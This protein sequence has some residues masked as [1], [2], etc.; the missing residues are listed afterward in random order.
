MLLKLQLCIS[1]RSSHFLALPTLS[2]ML[3]FGHEQYAQASSNEQQK[4]SD[5]PIVDFVQLHIAKWEREFGLWM[6]EAEVFFS[7]FYYIKFF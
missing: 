4:T 7:L 1:L 6:Y 2:D 3:S 5:M